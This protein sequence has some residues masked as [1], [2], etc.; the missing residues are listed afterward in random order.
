M[1]DLVKSELIHFLYKSTKT[2]GLQDETIQFYDSL[3][4]PTHSFSALQKP[5]ENDPKQV[6]LFY[7]YNGSPYRTCKFGQEPQF[8]MHFLFGDVLEDIAFRAGLQDSNLE[9]LSKLT[10]F[11]HF[12]VFCKKQ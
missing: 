7:K 10:G 4:N 5:N 11:H 1:G 6:D 9:S 3:K 12:E 8:H 2:E